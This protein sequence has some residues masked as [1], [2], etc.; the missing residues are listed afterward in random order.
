MTKWK[1]NQSKITENTD[2]KQIPASKKAGGSKWNGNDNR[3]DKSDIKAK[4]PKNKKFTKHIQKGKFSKNK[5]GESSEE[6]ELEVVSQKKQTQISTRVSNQI[7]RSRIPI[8]SIVH[9]TSFVHP[10]I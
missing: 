7:R 9:T 6:E 4:G 1:R 8:R 2:K 10:T 5:R 3:L